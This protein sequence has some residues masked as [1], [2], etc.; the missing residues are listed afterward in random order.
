MYYIGSKCDKSGIQVAVGN[1]SVIFNAITSSKISHI[2]AIKD[3]KNK[4]LYS[5]NKPVLT[6]KLVTFIKQ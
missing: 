5:E 2:Y 4:P 1:Q 6:A 3:G